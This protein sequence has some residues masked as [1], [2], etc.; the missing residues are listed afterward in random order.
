M[1]DVI[2]LDGAMGTELSRRGQD[3][4]APLWSARALAQAPDAV[5]AIHRESLRAGARVLT[6]CTFRTHERTL[7][8][9]QWEGRGAELN[10][11]AVR[12]AREAMTAEGV[13]DVRVAGSMSP[14]EDCFRPD[15]VPPREQL[16]PEHAQQARSLAQA[17][18]DLLL[19]E[20]MGTRRESSSAV[21][22]AVATGLTTWCSFTTSAPGILLSGEPLRD[23]VEAAEDLG[24]EA[25]L[26]NCIPCAD[27]LPDLEAL[28]QCATVPCGLYPNV[29]HARGVEGFRAELLLTP[30]DFAERMAE[31]VEGGA[32]I[33]GGCCG[34]RPEHVAA[35]AKALGDMA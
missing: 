8:R 4:S 33:V 13:M 20:T 22:A 3:T 6:T 25:I 21:T 23:A 9:A 12:C 5:T 29:G 19:V 18:A 15:L 27:V 2:L 28:L 10:A 35:L 34:T 30:E 32:E 11:L 31:C 1:S 26:L 14:L 7:R 24:A 17:G 16:V